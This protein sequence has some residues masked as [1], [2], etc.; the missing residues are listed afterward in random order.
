MRYQVDLFWV[1]VTVAT[2]AIFCS[3][4]FHYYVDKHLQSLSYDYRGKVNVFPNIV[5]V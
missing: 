4:L 1:N 3:S 5:A 2:A